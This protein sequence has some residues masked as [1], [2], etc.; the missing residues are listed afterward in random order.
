MVPKCYGWICNTR[1]SL[2]LGLA[3]S[4]MEGI[5]GLH[6]QQGDVEERP[7]GGKEVASDR[8][9]P[10]SPWSAVAQ[11]TGHTEAPLGSMLSQ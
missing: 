3:N 8:V 9:G 6:T 2:C 4:E 10:G 7:R 11:A 1:T 5:Q